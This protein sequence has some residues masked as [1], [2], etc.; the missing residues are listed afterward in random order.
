[1]DVLVVRMLSTGAVVYEL[2]SVSFWYAPCSRRASNSAGLVSLIWQSQPVVSKGTG[3]R[4][5]DVSVSAKVR[6]ASAHLA[7]STDRPARGSC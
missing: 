6:N 4:G 5:E 7:A 1:M 2:S 3:I